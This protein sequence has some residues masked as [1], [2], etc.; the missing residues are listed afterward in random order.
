MNKPGIGCL[1]ALSSILVAYT[2]H[3][4]AFAQDAAGRETLT[5]L[6]HMYEA[7]DEQRN[8]I[9]VRY[10]LTTIDSAAFKR[11]LNEP[12]SGADIPQ[13]ADAEYANKGTQTRSWKR[14]MEPPMPDG[15]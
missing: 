10:T 12:E 14:V 15:A 2:G 8:P 4:A 1:A 3:D 13:K 6:L 9:W 5:N 11:A 7:R